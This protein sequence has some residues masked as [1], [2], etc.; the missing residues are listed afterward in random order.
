MCL[1]RRNKKKYENNDATPSSRDAVLKE[2]QNAQPWL[3]RVNFSDASFADL[4][5]HCTFVVV[6]NTGKRLVTIE[7][8]SIHSDKSLIN[9]LYGS[10]VCWLRKVCL[11]NKHL[12]NNVFMNCFCKEGVRSKEDEKCAYVSQRLVNVN[13]DKVI[14][15][16]YFIVKGYTDSAMAVCQEAFT[17]MN[18]NAK[19]M[20]D[21]AAELDVK[22][23][24]TKILN[25]LFSNKELAEIFIRDMILNAAMLNMKSP[26]Y[27]VLPD[28]GSSYVITENGEPMVT[29]YRRN[30]GLF[31][32][33]PIT[34][35]D[36][37]FFLN[38]RRPIVM[39]VE[40]IAPVEVPDD[41]PEECDG[42]IFKNF[43]KQ[44][45]MAFYVKDKNE[46][47]MSFG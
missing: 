21:Y 24:P 25:G 22:Y 12:Y 34:E 47:S 46:Q 28:K 20:T 15:D 7:K 14:D 39:D 9:L 43:G 8:G 16:V 10:F 36:T 29:Y 37:P 38:I 3:G 5:T 11:I 35:N 1:F 23:K 42:I 40:N 6:D 13:F 2:I 19:R 32:S 31:C 33:T 27:E 44:R 26:K 45:I 18:L 41:L 4:L 17:L 30:S